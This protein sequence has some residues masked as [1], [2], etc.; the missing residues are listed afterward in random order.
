MRPVLLPNAPDQ[1]TPPNRIAADQ[2][3]LIL[4]NSATQLR[5]KRSVWDVN[6]QISSTD[7]SEARWWVKN[8][9]VIKFLHEGRTVKEIAIQVNRGQRHVRVIR[10]RLYDLRDCDAEMQPAKGS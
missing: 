4:G 5:R 9:E 10:E 1:R 8:R 3:G 2:P 7:R 6:S